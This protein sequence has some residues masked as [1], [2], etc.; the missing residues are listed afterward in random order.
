[1]KPMKMRRCL[2]PPPACVRRGC[3]RAE[4]QRGQKAGGAGVRGREGRR[5]GR[6]FSKEGILCCLING[7][8]ISVRHF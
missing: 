6:G 3:P 1:M 8:G 5:E 7:D 2:T 4:A